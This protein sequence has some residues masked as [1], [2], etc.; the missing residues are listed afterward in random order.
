M[1]TLPQRAVP[2][3]RSEALASTITFS[4]LLFLPALVCFFR[5]VVD[6]PDVWWHL[7][8]GQWIFQHR[9][10][11]TVDTFSFYGAGSPWAAYSWIPELLLYGLHQAFGLRGL[12]LFTAGLSVAIVAA[13]H[14]LAW[15][16]TQNSLL[17][18]VLTLAGALGLI[19]LETPRPWLFS[20]LLFVVELDLLL[21][22]GRTGNR[23]LLLWLVPL[24][25][26]WANVHIQFV[27]GLVVLGM[28]VAEPLLVRIPWVRLVDDDSSKI[29]F[30]WMLL[31][32]GL[33]L[34]AT[35][36]NP[37]HYHLYEVAAQLVGQASL[38]NLIQELGAMRFQ[39]V[40]NWIVLA[41]TVGAAFA[42][43]RKGRVRLLLWLLLAMGAYFSFRSRRDAWIVLFVGLTVLAYTAPKA[44]LPQR[45]PVPGRWRWAVAGL[46]AAGVVVGSLA[47]S[48]SKLQQKIASEYPVRAVEFVAGQGCSGPMFNPF[49]WGGYLIFNLPHVPVSID[50]RTMVH[51]EERLLR[52]AQTVRGREG[53]Q[54]DP[55]L[56]GARLVV[57]HRTGT[58]AV[59]VRLDDR[60]RLI[61]EDS[62]AVVFSRD[63]NQLT[64]EP[65]GDKRERPT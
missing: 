9:G 34:A 49:D 19:C 22:A 14:G 42:V 23:R 28:A 2:V 61:Y 38:W 13:F 48:E 10:W 47:V 57:L 31:I 27:L 41:V 39:S 40:D 62:V 53:W 32:F 20:I 36:L 11:P 4:A 3:S 29:S 55:E 21:T 7:R 5:D 58:L 1:S 30:R 54:L 60:F 15:R 35:L 51:G 24:F 18:V 26:F 16:L 45:F 52:H 6:D 43:G 8:A 33:C 56:A 50:G 63:M 65:T 64:Q 44:L 37:Y 59:L 17:A 12:V 46:V 25:A